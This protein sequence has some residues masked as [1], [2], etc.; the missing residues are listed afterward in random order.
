[1]E[2]NHP[3]FMSGYSNILYKIFGKDYMDYIRKTFFIITHVPDEINEDITL[4]NDY[5][6]NHK[7]IKNYLG[8]EQD[9]V[10]NI[11][12]EQCSMLFSRLKRSFLDVDLK[13]DTNETL[14]EKI[15]QLKEEEKKK[16][17]I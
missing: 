5:R 9:R 17:L 14:F 11:G 8:E 10:D 1:M 6:K 4:T 15:T 16:T 2:L 3:G 12:N 13:T 7:K